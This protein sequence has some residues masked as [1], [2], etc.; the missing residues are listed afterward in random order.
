MVVTIMVLTNMILTNMILTNMAE[1]NLVLTYM[2]HDKQGLARSLGLTFNLVYPIIK[3]GNITDNL[4]TTQRNYSIKSTVY[5]QER[6]VMA[7]IRYF[8]MNPS[9]LTGLFVIIWLLNPIPTRLG[10]VMLI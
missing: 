4:C 8:N 9:F 10:H 2:L 3:S 6:V 7:R 5:I 1:T